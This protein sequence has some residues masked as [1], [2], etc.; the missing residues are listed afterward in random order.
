MK[1]LKNDEEFLVCSVKDNVYL[2][3]LSTTLHELKAWTRK[4]CAKT[5]YEIL[6]NVWKESRCRLNIP[7]DIRGANI[8]LCE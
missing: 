7:Q 1:F 6:R 8:E 3:P 4:S 2:T 5:D